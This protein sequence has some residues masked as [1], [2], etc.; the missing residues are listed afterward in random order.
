MTTSEIISIAFSIGAIW[1][2]LTRSETV[3]KDPNHAATSDELMRIRLAIEKLTAETA[4]ANAARE[5]N[6]AKARQDSFLRGSK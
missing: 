4:R 6:E 3:V 1:L 5:L 2:A